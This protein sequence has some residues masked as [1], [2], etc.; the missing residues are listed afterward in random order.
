[1]GSPSVQRG[2]RAEPRVQPASQRRS[3]PAPVLKLS[4]VMELA[5]N[6][7][8]ELDSGSDM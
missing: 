7:P 6:Q 3:E 1:M 2:L 4:A 5:H 8:Q